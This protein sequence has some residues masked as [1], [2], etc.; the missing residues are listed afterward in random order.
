MVDFTYMKQSETGA[1]HWFPDLPG[2][3]D[4]FGAV[5]WVE[6]DAPPETPFVSASL[7]EVAGTGAWIRLWH[8]EVKTFHDYPNN[9]AAIEGAYEAGWRIPDP[10]PLEKETE[11]DS[12]EAPK[13]TRKSSASADKA[14]TE[15]GN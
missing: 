14:E 3:K 10:E 5:G 9:A 1:G 7:D 13:K 8:P 12:S 15:E 6:A 2:V 4:R 11:P